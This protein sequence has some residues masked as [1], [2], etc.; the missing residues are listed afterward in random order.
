MT[1][2]TRSDRLAQWLDSH[3]SVVAAALAVPKVGDALRYYVEKKSELARERAQTMLTASSRLIEL[4]PISIVERAGETAE[5]FGILDEAIS[6][7]ANASSSDVVRAIGRRLAEAL[8]GD[9]SIDTASVDIRTLTELSDADV[10]VLGHVWAQCHSPLVR[11]VA[12]DLGL[13]VHTEA[14]FAHLRRLGLLVPP[15]ADIDGEELVYREDRSENY[16][17]W[18]LSAYGR[19]ITEL[20]AAADPD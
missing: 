2:P 9:Q 20:I 18:E 16:A 10:R 7:A 13:G 1:E 5:A 17:G 3:P 4:D 8:R 11:H 6:G 12:E 15:G 14:I 19:A